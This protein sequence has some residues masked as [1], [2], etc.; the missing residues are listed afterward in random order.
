M[1]HLH[2][3]TDA[4]QQA[5]Y[6]NRHRPP[7]V[8]TLEVIEARSVI[9][10][11]CCDDDPAREILAYYLPDGELLAVA[12]PY[13]TPFQAEPLTYR[14]SHQLVEDVRLLLGLVVGVNTDTR[15]AQR[16]NEMV[17]QHDLALQQQPRVDE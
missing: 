9:G 1:E 17:E 11:G 4:V 10:E 13:A 3:S 7:A 2:A 15:A 8:R 12:D 5:V 14:N 16:L 6:A